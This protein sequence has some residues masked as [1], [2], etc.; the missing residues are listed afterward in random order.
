MEFP[1]LLDP[2]DDQPPATVITRRS[3]TADGKVLVRGVASDN[4]ADQDGDGERPA[5]DGHGAELRRVGGRAGR[6]TAELRSRPTPR[7]P[8][9]TWKR[10]RMSWR[11]RTVPDCLLASRERERPEMV[12]SIAPLLGALTLSSSPAAPFYSTPPSSRTIEKKWRRHASM[13]PGLRQGRRGSNHESARCSTPA[14]ALRER[15]PGGPRSGLG[16]GPRR[17]RRR[18]RRHLSTPPTTAPTS[19]TRTPSA[20][21][22]ATWTAASRK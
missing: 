6:G 20:S 5:G 10:T 18:R 2:V 7:T 11:C 4:G 3:P 13:L 22:S 14:P 16:R 17:P 9:A 21:L 19:P 1:K 12:A 15:F 8:P